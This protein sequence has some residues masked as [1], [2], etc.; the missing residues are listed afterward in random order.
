MI[1]YLLL[2]LIYNLFSILTLPINIPSLPD[3]ITSIMNQFA[4]Y[5]STGI[6]IIGN[7]FDV[8]YLL[9]LF[10]LVISIDVGISLYKFVMYIIRK[11]PMM[12]IK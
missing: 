9:V 7:Y 3:S 4:S 11:I 10:G 12:N 6:A 1:I 8:G 5:L 2:E